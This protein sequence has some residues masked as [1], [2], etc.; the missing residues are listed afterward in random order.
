MNEKIVALCWWLHNRVPFNF[1]VK[2]LETPGDSEFPKHLST[3]IWPK[4]QSA[5]EPNAIQTIY[6][7]CNS[8][9]DVSLITQYNDI[10]RSYLDV[11]F[12]PRTELEL[13]WILC[14]LNTLLDVSLELSRNELDSHL[15]TLSG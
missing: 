8:I 10:I 6:I 2:V 4:D 3:D 7:V 12:T 1:N 5:E 15:G 13:S 9:T 11:K 14:N